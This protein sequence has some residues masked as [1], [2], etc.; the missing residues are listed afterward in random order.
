MFGLIQH[1]TIEK[2]IAV[3]INRLTKNNEFKDG[4]KR[5]AAFVG[6]FYLEK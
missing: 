1:P 6:A 5:T 4:N 2:Q 3:I